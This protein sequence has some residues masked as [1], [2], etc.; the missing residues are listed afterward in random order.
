MREFFPKEKEISAGIA[1]AADRK[2]SHSG[3]LKTGKLNRKQYTIYRVGM[4][5]KLKKILVCCS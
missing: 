1:D 3:R 5:G 4:Q 2:F